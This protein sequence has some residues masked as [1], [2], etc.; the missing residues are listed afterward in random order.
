[1]SWWLLFC[2]IY[3]TKNG[4]FIQI[5]QQDRRISLRKMIIF[6]LRFISFFPLT[7]YHTVMRS[8]PLWVGKTPMYWK[9]IVLL[10]LGYYEKIKSQN[11]NCAPWI[12]KLWPSLSPH[13]TPIVLEQIGST[14]HWLVLYH[15]F[16]LFGVIKQC[17]ALGNWLKLLYK[18]FAFV[19]Y[20]KMICTISTNNQLE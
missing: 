18:Y 15:T 7:T 4:K 16:L 17:F 1:M 9:C 10:W 19:N 11:E 8:I 2:E 20:R 14:H 12:P 3:K 6:P 5:A 13:C